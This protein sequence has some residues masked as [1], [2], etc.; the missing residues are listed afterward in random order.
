MCSEEEFDEKVYYKYY[1]KYRILSVPA[2]S[3]WL[4]LSLETGTLDEQ[5]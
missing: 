4:V 1:L 5:N 3:Y 2:V